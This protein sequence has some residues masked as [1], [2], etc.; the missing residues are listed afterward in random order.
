MKQVKS[1][2]IIVCCMYTE[3][4]LLQNH[5]NGK[6]LCP[7]KFYIATE[8]VNKFI[9]AKFGISPA[10]YDL[11]FSQQTKSATV[12]VINVFRWHCISFSHAYQN[13]TPLQAYISWSVQYCRAVFTCTVFMAESILV[14]RNKP[15]PFFIFYFHC[16]LESAWMCIFNQLFNLLKPSPVC[17]IVFAC[18]FM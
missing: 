13:C 10:R 9:L 8:I 4:C 2:Q 7:I 18:F 14:L 16:V 6:S 3:Y 17:I 12:S 15:E 5:S 1:V 11:Y